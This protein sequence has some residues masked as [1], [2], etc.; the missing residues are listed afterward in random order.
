MGGGQEEGDGGMAGE[1]VG[2]RKQDQWSS[3]HLTTWRGAI[4]FCGGSGAIVLLLLLGKGNAP[5]T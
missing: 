4:Q 3:A 2:R 1:E 5:F